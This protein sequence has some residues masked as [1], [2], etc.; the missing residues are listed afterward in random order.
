M[1]TFNAKEEYPKLLHELDLA[2]Q[3]IQELGAERDKLREACEAFLA[4]Y[5]EDRLDRA[6]YHTG[7]I[8]DAHRM[9]REALGHD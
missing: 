4:A 5:K 2:E 7:S 9:T 3:R 1:S 6:I 8:H